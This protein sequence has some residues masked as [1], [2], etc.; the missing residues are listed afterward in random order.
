MFC[1][2]KGIIY[3]RARIYRATWWIYISRKVYDNFYLT[4]IRDTEAHGLFEI[5]VGSD[6][7]LQTEPKIRCNPDILQQDTQFQAERPGLR[8]CIFW[9]WLCQS[10]SCVSCSAIWFRWI[11]QFVGIQDEARDTAWYIGWI[12]TFYPFEWGRKKIRIFIYSRR[13]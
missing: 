13:F 5:R 8:K 11:T 12:Q 3:T 6:T 2:W 10:C 1:S 4:W 9:S 7:W